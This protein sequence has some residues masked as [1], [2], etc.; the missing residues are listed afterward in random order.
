MGGGLLECH[1]SVFGGRNRYAD[2]IFSE[3]IND[4]ICHSACSLYSTHL[5]GSTAILNSADA[6]PEDAGA[7]VTAAKFGGSEALL[8]VLLVMLGA[9]VQAMQFVFEEKVM[10]MDDAAPPLLLIGMEGVWGTAIC[11]F[12]LYPLAYFLPGDDHGSYEDGYNTWYMIAHSSTIQMAFVIYFFAIFG[13]N[14]FAVLVTFSLNSIWHAILD[15]FRPIT[16]W[17]TD[18]FIFYVIT[19]SFG[20]PWTKYGWIQVLGMIVLL[21]G[22]AVYNSDIELRGQWYVFGLQFRNEYEE[23]EM[24]MQEAE[25]DA[26][27]EARQKQFGQRRPSSMAEHSPYVSVHTQALRGLA[28]PKI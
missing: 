20:E 3:H 23:I 11:L 10:S 13:Y 17:G 14:L 7:S 15:N 24:E 1:F 27:W 4:T 18:M 22:T 9:F 28:S 25:M 6:G 5:S 12:I 21:Y 8:G 2:A 26:E 19:S 16:V